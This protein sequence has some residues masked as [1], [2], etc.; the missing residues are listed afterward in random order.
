M[1]TFR[2]PRPGILDL[3]TNTSQYPPTACKPDASTTVFSVRFKCCISRRK[4]SSLEEDET[5]ELMTGVKESYLSYPMH[6]HRGMHSFSKLRCDWRLEIF[7]CIVSTLIKRFRI[8]QQ[9]FE[10]AIS[11]IYI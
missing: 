10:D 5:V 11:D 7:L 8:G 9:P 6:V 2:V 4:E 1:A 3:P